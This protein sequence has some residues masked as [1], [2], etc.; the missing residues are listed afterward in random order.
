VTTA[1]MSPCYGAPQPARVQ[2]DR[3]RTGGPPCARRVYGEATGRCVAR[4]NRGVSGHDA[5]LGK[6]C[7]PRAAGHRAARGA[8]VEAGRRAGACD[9]A[10]R[11][12]SSLNVLLALC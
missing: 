10:A 12:R 7:G 3:G 8:D 4:A 9:V 5:G 2:A 11:W 1:K 6:A